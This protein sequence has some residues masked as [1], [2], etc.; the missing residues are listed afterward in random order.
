MLC[1][2]ESDLFLIE[3]WIILWLL[4]PNRSWS[5]FPPFTPVH[6]K[7]SRRRYTWPQ[8]CEK[9]P[10]WNW[11]FTFL[12]CFFSPFH[13]WGH[14]GPW[15]AAQCHHWLAQWQVL[16]AQK[17]EASW[18]QAHRGATVGGGDPAAGQ[19]SNMHIAVALSDFWL[20]SAWEL[21][22]QLPYSARWLEGGAH[23]LLGEPMMRHGDNPFSKRGH[24]AMS[25]KKSSYQEEKGTRRYTNNS[26]HEPSPS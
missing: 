23:F 17:V 7:V 14:A 26:S 2:N 10:L 22:L 19:G 8:Q 25:W 15:G 16:G 24:S 13:L 12:F 4:W 1:L 5:D 3:D 11:I 18:R 9:F 6:W 20:T 21:E